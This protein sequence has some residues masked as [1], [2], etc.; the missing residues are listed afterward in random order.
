MPQPARIDWLGAALGAVAL[1]GP[2][3]GLTEQ[4]VR[5]WDSVVVGSIALGVVAGVLFILQERRSPAPMMPLELFSHRNF[6]IGNLATLTTYM[7]LGAMTFLLPLF[8]QQVAHYARSRRASRY[9]PSPRRCSCSRGASAA[10]PTG[11]VHGC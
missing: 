11:S 1:A 5:G 2:V 4:P 8:L 7:G 10:S 3:F 9:S 6:T